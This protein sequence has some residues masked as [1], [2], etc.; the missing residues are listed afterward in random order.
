M[1]A[2]EASRNADFDVVVIGAVAAGA[3]V[4]GLV[5][6]RADLRSAA[7]SYEGQH[8]GCALPGLRSSRKPGK[9]SPA[10][11]PVFPDAPKYA[12]TATLR[13]TRTL[14][15]VTPFKPERFFWR[16]LGSC[17]F[18]RDHETS[19]VLTETSPHDMV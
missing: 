11:R 7:G 10:T 13:R 9:C 1:S 4:S 17:D 16:F 2:R 5:A 3:T 15:R 18:M 8:R 19:S 6:R 14:A 12:V